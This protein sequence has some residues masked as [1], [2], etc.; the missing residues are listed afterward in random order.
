MGEVAGRL[1]NISIVTT[2]NPRTEKPEDIIS[3]IEAGISKTKGN[4]KIIVDRK[5]AI[6]EAIRMANKRDI[7][8]LAG[9]GHET[10][11]EING[12]K[13]EFDERKIV[14]EILENM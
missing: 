8:I 11:Q 3:D 10:Y 12:V 4:Y 2:D 7:V 5:E 1:A 14:K 13:N 9:K 6:A